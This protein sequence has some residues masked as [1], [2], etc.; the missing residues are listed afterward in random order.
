MRS[1]PAQSAVIV[2]ERTELFMRR[3]ISAS[4]AG[5]GEFGFTLINCVRKD[6]F[7]RYCLEEGRNFARRIPY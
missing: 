7:E 5:S 1:I 6:E 2:P 3:V 4:A